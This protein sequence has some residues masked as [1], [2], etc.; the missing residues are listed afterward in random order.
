M[1]LDRRQ[2]MRLS[3]IGA[4]S[5]FMT[6][7]GFAGAQTGGVAPDSSSKA[8]GGEP[9]SMHR[10]LFL[11]DYHIERMDGLVRTMHTPAKR[12]AVLRPDRPW[13]GDS[14]QI[15]S[16]PVYDPDSRLYKMWYARHC[17]AESDDGVNWRKPSLGLVEFQGSRDNNLV[18]TPGG[19]SLW[20]ALRDPV[21]PDPQRRYKGLLGE[22]G[23][24]QPAVSADGLRWRA[25]ESS[26][27]IP[28]EDEYQLNYD[29]LGQQFIATVKHGTQ[30]GRSV[31]LTTSKDFEHWSEQTLI[32]H[33]D[34]ADLEVVRRRIER[35]LTDPTLL[36]LFVNNPEQYRAEI[37]NMPVFPYEDLYVGLPTKFNASGNIPPPRGNQDGINLVELAASRDLHTW[38]RLGERDAFIPP[39][40]INVGA[41]DTGQL[42][43]GSRPLLR[44]DELWFYYTGLRYR[45]RYDEWLNDTQ[46]KPSDEDMFPDGWGA[47]CLGVLR[48]DGF[49]SLDARTQ[50][51]VVTKP[52]PVSGPELYLN[53]GTMTGEIS[54]QALDDAETV[55]AASAPWRGDR[56]HGAVQWQ[57]GAGL[58]GLVGRTVRLRLTLSAASLYSAW[59]GA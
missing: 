57:E 56:V 54:V 26:S 8:Q 31:Y 19:A 53:A 32:M 17:Y 3:T 40:P 27:P 51:I 25:L 37:Y 48:R 13:E 15:R 43:A 2:F 35:H 30:W 29:E 58:S 38:M 16:A 49:V 6:R 41:Y 10:M 39:S 42:L 46:G 18:S 14:P 34:D 21:D 52:V 47:I 45:Y 50:G 36:S 20:L 28:T 24:L 9:T 44:N 22:G 7:L 5:A 59:F 11:D 1:K 33:S 55:V 12:G 23:P 4:G